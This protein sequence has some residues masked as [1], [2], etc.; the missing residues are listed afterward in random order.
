M[1]GSEEDAVPVP[2][3]SREDNLAYD[4]KN[5][6]AYDISPMSSVMDVA[7]YSRDSVQ[8]L[9]NK[10]FMLPRT[11]GDEG[12]MV[13]LPAEDTFRLPRS[14]PIPKEK[15]KTR[16]QKFME[17]RNMK[18]R[19]RSRLVWDEIEGDW[20][21]RWGYKSIKKSQDK[22]NWVHE[23]GQ[24][25]DPNEN[26]FDKAKAEQRLVKARQKMREVRNQVE[27][28]GGKLRASV[29]DLVGSQKRGKDG[30]REA[31]KRAQVSS[32]SYGKFDRIAPNEATNL[33]PTRKKGIAPVSSNAEKDSY[34]KTVGR[35]LSGDGYIDKHKAAKVGVTRERRND[36]VG[37]SEMQCA[38]ASEREERVQAA[39]QTR[40]DR[41]QFVNR[42][43]QE[44]LM[45]IQEKV[46]P[47]LEALVTAVLLERP[48]DPSFFML[49][50]LCEQTKSL[51][52][53]E[54]GGGQRASSIAEEASSLAPGR[55]TEAIS[56]CQAA[57]RLFCIVSLRHFP[58][59]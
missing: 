57:A 19:K 9:I 29:P 32:A 4:L 47:V 45:Y 52:G 15:P 28:A 13:S 2:T 14:K 26:P 54:Q 50:W 21:P 23:V 37:P 20:K 58:C 8:L 11:Q 10:L 46:N 34:L 38:L 7:A 33:Q 41:P 18:K 36:A 51:D 48:D 3:A 24:H 25:E 16:W 42:S 5:M 27:A 43:A 39:Q 12:T 35:V 30:L 55:W 22:A 44:H 59:C 40:S 6:A 56:A 17:E 31:V 49:R 1:P 53:P